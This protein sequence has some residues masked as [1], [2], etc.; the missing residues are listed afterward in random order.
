[1][2]LNSLNEN[3]TLGAKSGDFSVSD[4]SRKVHVNS[5]DLKRGRADGGGRPGGV[6]R[7]D[8]V[9]D[10]QKQYEDQ[11]GGPQHSFGSDIMFT[12]KKSKYT[13]NKR[14]LELHYNL[15]F[16]LTNHAKKLMKEG[17][18]ALQEEILTGYTKKTFETLIYFIESK[19]DFKKIVN[20]ICLINFTNHGFYKDEYD[21]IILKIVQNF[22]IKCVYVLLKMDSFGFF[23]IKN[24][25]FGVSDFNF[26]NK[27]R[28]LFGGK[29]TL[30]D[31]VP[32]SAQS[33]GIQFNPFSGTTGRDERRMTD[34][35][36]Q[37]KQSVG[38]GVTGGA[39]RG[40][41]APVGGHGEQSGRDHLPSRQQLQD[42]EVHSEAARELIRHLELPQGLQNQ[43]RS[44]C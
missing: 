10:A 1:M 30:L 36:K 6:P 25:I 5:A 8:I 13:Q 17:Y 23:T 15:L 19:M 29:G 21:E 42:H 41:D 31:R 20:L 12:H 43:R 40:G 16:A 34:F 33:S 22:P 44:G 3:D 39:A 11:M 14:V 9:I 2:V 26:K 7:L 35:N 38:A 37:A 28:N 18:N 27:K 4:M 32:L 24:D